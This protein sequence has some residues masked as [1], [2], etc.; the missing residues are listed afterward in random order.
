VISLKTAGGSGVRA[1]LGQLDNMFHP[2]AFRRVDKIALL[3]LNL[4]GR[5]NQKEKSIDPLQRTGN[6]LRLGE[7]AFD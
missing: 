5:G 2:A 6:R 1:Q 4:R 3:L 7:I